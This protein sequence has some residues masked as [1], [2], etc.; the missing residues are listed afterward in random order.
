MSNFLQHSLRNTSVTDNHHYI[1]NEGLTILYIANNSPTLTTSLNGVLKAAGLRENLP[2]G[3]ATWPTF[4]EI[5]AFH[6]QLLPTL[7]LVLKFLRCE[8]IVRDKISDCF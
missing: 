2:P 1:P 3:K 7:Q 4:G 5:R 6:Y 8:N